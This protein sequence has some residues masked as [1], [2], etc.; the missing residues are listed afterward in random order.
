MKFAADCGCLAEGD[1]HSSITEH[2]EGCGFL[3]D[4]TRRSGHGGAWRHMAGVPAAKRPPDP[5]ELALAESYQRHD[6]DLAAIEDAY[7]DDSWRTWT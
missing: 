7:A 4:L 3:E 2:R 6:G 1:E 5:A